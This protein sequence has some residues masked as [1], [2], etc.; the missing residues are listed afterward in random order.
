MIWQSGEIICSVLLSS[1]DNSV[2]TFL[3]SNFG[4][5]NNGTEGVWSHA[6]FR[7]TS[8][9]RSSSAE[10]VSTCEPDT[11]Q[12]MIRVKMPYV[13]IRR[14]IRLVRGVHERLQI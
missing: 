3:F 11:S 8:W 14:R 1:E 10:S 6:P 5:A 12:A 13:E 9:Y 4:G 2:L 7:M